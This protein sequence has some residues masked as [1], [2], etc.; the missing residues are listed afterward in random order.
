MRVRIHTLL[1]DFVTLEPSGTS[2]HPGS[3]SLGLET[4]VQGSYLQE[5]QVLC[6]LLDQ[7][8]LCVLRIKFGQEVKG[9]GLLCW[10]IVI[11]NLWD[12]RAIQLPLPAPSAPSLAAKR[13]VQISTSFVKQFR[14][15]EQT[16]QP[17]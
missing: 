4:R 2:A 6:D 15:L 10:N 11:Q 7:L 5:E 12:T 3:F 14:H 17:K 9:D 13:S 8:L 16:N 1:I